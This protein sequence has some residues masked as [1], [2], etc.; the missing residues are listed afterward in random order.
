MATRE[1]QV[2]GLSKSKAKIFLGK[3]ALGE[4]VLECGPYEAFQREF[5]Q[6]AGV[7]NGQVDNC[8]TLQMVYHKTRFATLP[9]GQDIWLKPQE[10]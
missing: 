6:K 3:V 8:R 7:K 1:D 5:S 2:C 10:K 4:D 9:D